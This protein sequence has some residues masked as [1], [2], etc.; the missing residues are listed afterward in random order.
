M[1]HGLKQRLEK[2]FN[3]YWSYKILL[4]TIAKIPKLI[5]Y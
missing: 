1:F 2:T 4:L 5:L 3:F